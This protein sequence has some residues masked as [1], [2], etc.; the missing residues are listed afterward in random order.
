MGQRKRA[1]RRDE[2]RAELPITGSLIGAS[3]RLA[4]ALEKERDRI[5]ELQAEA[6]R[7]VRDLRSARSRSCST[8]S[9]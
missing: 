2:R 3:E 5:V 8:R 7:L 6:Q 4:D 9:R 1:T